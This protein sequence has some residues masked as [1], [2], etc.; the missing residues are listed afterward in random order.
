MKKSFL[1]LLT[2][3]IFFFISL[4]TFAHYEKHVVLKDRL[5]NFKLPKKWGYYYFRHANQNSLVLFY[6]RDAVVNDIGEPIIPALI[7]NIEYLGKNIDTIKYSI[8]SR[9]KF[10][11]KKLKNI[12]NW[13]RLKIY[14]KSA[15]VFTGTHYDKRYKRNFSRILYSDVYNGFGICIYFNCTSDV[16]YNIKNECYNFIKSVRYSPNNKNYKDT[17]KIIK[18]NL[19]IFT[20]FSNA[21]KKAEK[22]RQ[23]LFLMRNF[24]KYFFHSLNNLRYATH[25]FP[26]FEQ[27][28]LT[29]IHDAYILGKKWVNIVNELYKQIQS[30]W[31]KY[32]NE[33]LIK[34]TIIRFMIIFKK[35]RYY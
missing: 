31:Y 20:N 12:Y 6:K 15:I 16:F 5:I 27:K 26:E 18:S 32:S 25:N 21:F 10:P 34:K 30:F 11:I 9:L 1:H 8:K 23:I 35:L 14:S 19:K 33:A 17:V 28:I 24:N 3:I 2:V 22:A 13:Q 4:Q 29:P 7:I